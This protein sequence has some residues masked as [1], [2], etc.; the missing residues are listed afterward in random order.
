MAGPAE[1][2]EQKGEQGPGDPATMVQW[3]G[4]L[5]MPS[6]GDSS[7]S[8]QRRGLGRQTT[9]LRGQHGVF[10]LGIPSQ[11]NSPCS[12]R[13][14]RRRDLQVKLGYGVW[15]RFEVMT[16]SLHPPPQ[17][18]NCR[19]S[20]IGAPICSQLDLSPS[21]EDVHSV[22]YT[23][24]LVATL[25]GRRCSPSSVQC[26]RLSNWPIPQFQLFVRGQC[27]QM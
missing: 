24:V 14:Q 16:L 4:G 13:F 15:R 22:R 18:W 1:T 19:R 10:V 26:L 25:R 12:G 2:G 11:E 5:C 6:R 23:S 7:R 9:R 27:Q 21:V 17:P 8:G 20:G 3:V